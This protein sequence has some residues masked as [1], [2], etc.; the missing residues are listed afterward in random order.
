MNILYISNILPVPWAGPT[1]SVPKQIQA[2]RKYDNVFW[3][4]V[5]N[6]NKDENKKWFT[7]VDWNKY[8]YYADLS[9]YPT[10]NIKS[11]PYPFCKPDLII[12]E[13]FYG[14]ARSSIIKQLEKIDIPYIIVPR[15]ELTKAAQKRKLI[16]KF[17]GNFFIFNK[18]ARKAKAIHYLTPQEHEDSG[19]KWNSNYF[20]IPNGIKPSIT[21]KENYFKDS[22]LNCI[23][24]G[25]I[26][27]YQKGFD[28]LIE[29]CSLVQDDLRKADCNIKIYGPDR[30]GRL[31]E[32][33]KQAISSGVADIL[34]FNDAIY[35]EEKIKMLLDC[36]VFVM[37]SRFE[38]HPMALIEAMDYGLPCVA[39]KGS[40]MKELIE[41]YD[42]GW[43]AECTSS[44]IAKALRNMLIDKKNIKQ[45]GFNAVRL[46]AEY[47]WDKLAKKSHEEYSK[48]IKNNS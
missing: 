15:G 3:Y 27:P 29:A 42:A 35:G 16:K 2:Q 12:V 8:D 23:A 43:T 38:G 37:T 48:F 13:Q 11:L 40:N 47:D 25:R 22:K 36:D 30:V 33:K 26:E 6:P 4:N 24:I 31:N 18:F 46:A 7:D 1:Y 10:E 41:E 44:S 28:I 20:I 21:K 19:L 9:V 14:F 39:T 5:I 34:S 32:L 45:K 17:L